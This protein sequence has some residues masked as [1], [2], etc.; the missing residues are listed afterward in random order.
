[1]LLFF[2]FTFVLAI[3]ACVHVA[4]IKLSG[5][6]LNP[7]FSGGLL[8]WRQDGHEVRCK[9]SRQGEGGSCRR[10]F[11]GKREDDLP[12]N[13]SPPSAWQRGEGVGKGLLVRRLWVQ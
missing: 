6:F 4:P 8:P 5:D 10:G 7:P 1:M 12:A 11:E 3:T 9:S 13:R 2:F